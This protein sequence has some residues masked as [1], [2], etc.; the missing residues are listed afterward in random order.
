[1]RPHRSLVLVSSQQFCPVCQG[2][3]VVAMALL[4]RVPCPHCRPKAWHREQVAIPDFP[5]RSDIPRGAA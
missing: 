2:A 3:G 4:G 5:V 1:M